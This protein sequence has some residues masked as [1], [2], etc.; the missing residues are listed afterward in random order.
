MTPGRTRAHAGEWRRPTG[1]SRPAA[2]LV[3]AGLVVGLL[4]WALPASAH[5]GLVSSDPADG[6]VLAE[7]PASITLTF[8]EPVTLAEGGTRLHDADG[9]ELAVEGRSVDEVVSVVPPDLPDGTFVL[10]FRVVSADGHP[11]TGSLSFSVEAPAEQ[12]VVGGGASGADSAALQ[13]VHGLVQGVGYAALLGGAGLV[14]FAAL[15]LPPVPALQRAR[16]RLRTWS[17]GTAAV[18]ALAWVLLVPIGIA[19]RQGTGVPGVLAGDAWSDWVSADG[20]L[21][22]LVVVGLGSASLGLS[23]TG[24]RWRVPAVAGAGLAVAAVPIVGHTRSF[25]PTWLVVGSDVVHVAA[26]ATWLGGLA[27]LVLTLSVIGTEE[28]LAARV[29]ARFSTVAAAL[30]ALVAVAGLLLGWRILG[31][32]SGL[33]STSYGLVL[34]VKTAAVAAVVG[35]A[36]WNRYGLL[37]SVAQA[38][39][40]PQRTGQRTG[41]AGRLRSAV[42]V[43]ATGL[44]GVL[45]LT[46]FLV[47]QV[48]GP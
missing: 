23:P 17:L 11:V 33:V 34:L 10:T 5:T 46:G 12:A 15:L 27:G 47:N 43:E 31:S 37:P 30:L 36:A 1:R 19:H 8:T 29:L 22:A 9:G 38:A 48:P 20:L 35:V 21:A 39:G 3:L 16:S 24:A 44:V 28:A 18:A 13:V 6:A 45:L 41:A 40:H 42:R 32:W 14:V 4:V 25:G 26:A 2:V 7:A